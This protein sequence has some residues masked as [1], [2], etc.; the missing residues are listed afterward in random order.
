MYK[1]L[2]KFEGVIYAIVTAIVLTFVVLCYIDIN[3]NYSNTIRASEISTTYYKVN[4]MTYEGDF[5]YECKV[6]L[7][8][9]DIKSGKTYNMECV[10]FLITEELNNEG[11][12][13]LVSKQPIAR[14]KFS[15]KTATKNDEVIIIWHLDPSKVE[16]YQYYKDEYFMA[17]E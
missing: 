15:F 5:E 10:T 7:S 6:P 4:D 9:F 8:N 14:K 17:D 3:S 1:F 11:R 2:E 12:L 16:R 13:V